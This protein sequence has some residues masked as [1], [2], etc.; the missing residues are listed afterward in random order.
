MK[1]IKRIVEEQI[2]SQTRDKLGNA[3]IKNVRS[4]L[5]K[6]EI[7]KDSLKP[8]VWT[9]RYYSFNRGDYFAIS[10]T[11]FKNYQ[12]IKRVFLPVS[13]SGVLIDGGYEEFY[14]VMYS[15]SVYSLNGISFS[16]PISV[17]NNTNIYFRTYYLDQVSDIEKTVVSTEIIP[18]SNMSFNSGEISIELPAGKWVTLELILYRKDSQGYIIGF[19]NLIEKIDDWRFSDSEPPE[20]PKWSDPPLETV[21]DPVSGITTNTLR[22]QMPDSLDW[23]GH[24]IYQ[25]TLL[26]KGNIGTQPIP[27]QLFKINSSGEIENSG[28]KGF[29][30]TEIDPSGLNTGSK[31]ELRGRKYTVAGYE[32]I[33]G[34]LINNGDFSQYT[35]KFKDWKMVSSPSLLN[36][37]S[38]S[39]SWDENNSGGVCI[40]CSAKA[41]G[42][43]KYVYLVHT[44]YTAIDRSKDYIL[45][46][47]TSYVSGSRT[48][49]YGIEYN[50]NNSGLL[51]ATVFFGKQFDTSDGWIKH[52]L[53]IK[54][55]TANVYNSI[56]NNCNYFRIRAYLTQGVTG[57]S[58]RIFDTIKLAEFN[59][60]EIYSTQTSNSTFIKT[61]E[62]LT[63]PYN[64]YFKV[65]AQLDKD[66]VFVGNISGLYQHLGQSRKR[67]HDVFNCFSAGRE[68][69]QPVLNYIKNGMFV[70]QTDWVGS[71]V[72]SFSIS[73]SN[74]Y[75]PPFG[76]S[77]GIITGKDSQKSVLK[78][79]RQTVSGAPTARGSYTLSVYAKGDTCTSLYLAGHVSSILKSTVIPITK[80]W[81]RYSLF[82]SSNSFNSTKYVYIGIPTEKSGTIRISGAQLEYRSTVT[83]FHPKP[84]NDIYTDGLTTRLSCKTRISQFSSDVF[85]DTNHGTLRLFYTPDYDSDKADTYKYLVSCYKNPGGNPLTD[86]IDCYYQPSSRQFIFS[87][88]KSSIGSS[89]KSTSQS[90]LRGD[91]LCL[92][93][94]WGATS[95]SIYVDGKSGYSAIKNF[96]NFVDYATIGTYYNTALSLNYGYPADGTIAE[97][98]TSMNQFNGKAIMIDAE[99]DGIFPPPDINDPTN[100]NIDGSQY[101]LIGERK[102][103]SEDVMKLVDGVF[104]ADPLTFTHSP[105]TPN[106]RY[107]YVISAYDFDRNP[108]IYSDEQW[109]VAGDKIPPFPITSTS[110]VSGY[111][112]VTYKWLNP[113]DDDFVQCKIYKTNVYSTPNVIDNVNGNPSEFNSWTTNTSAG[114]HDVYITTLDFN[115]NENKNGVKISCTSLGVDNVNTNIYVNWVSTAPA[116]LYFKSDASKL[117]AVTVT[118]ELLLA[119]PNSNYGIAMYGNDGSVLLS[120]TS[121]FSPPPALKGNVYQYI[122]SGIA[123]TFADGAE[124][125]GTIKFKGRIGNT[126]VNQSLAVTF[127]KTQPTAP[128]IALRNVSGGPTNYTGNKQVVTAQF[129]GLVSDVYQCQLSTTSG[130]SSN[131][132]VT[133]FNTCPLILPDIAKTYSIRGWVMDKAL[134]VSPVSNTLTYAYAGIGIKPG[135]T[136]RNAPTTSIIE[137]NIDGWYNQYLNIL[138]S[139]ETTSPNAIV[140][141]DYTVKRTNPVLSDLTGNVTGSGVTLTR[142][143]TLGGATADAVNEI[144]L[145]AT[146]RIGN[147]AATKLIVKQDDTKPSVMAS[148]WDNTVTGFNNNG[149]YLKWKTGSTDN[150]SGI[151]QYD[152]YRT[153]TGFP[154]TLKRIG[155]VSSTISYFTDNEDVL[156][157]YAS[158]DYQL[159]VRDIA[160]NTASGIIKSIN[161]VAPWDRTFRNW[162]DNGS[163][164]RDNNQS[165]SMVG[166][167][168]FSAS[169]KLSGSKSFYLPNSGSYLSQNLMLPEL[170]ST[171]IKSDDRYVLSFYI[172]N[173]APLPVLQMIYYD[174]TGASIVLASAANYEEWSTFTDGVSAYD[175]NNNEWKRKYRVFNPNDWISNPLYRGKAVYVRP[176]F[177]IPSGGANYIDNIQWEDRKSTDTT[178]TKFID[179]HTLTADRFH[180]GFIRANMIKV[181][182]LHAGLFHA[183]GV[184]IQNSQT[185]APYLQIGDYVTGES[186]VRFSQYGGYRHFPGD[187]LGKGYQFLDHVESG[188]SR[189]GTVNFRNTF[190]DWNGNQVIPKVLINLLTYMPFNSY[191][192]AD[193]QFIDIRMDVTPTGFTMTPYLAHI[194]PVSASESGLYEYAPSNATSPFVPSTNYDITFTAA[195]NVAPAEITSQVTFNYTVNWSANASPS[196]PEAVQV[197]F[198]TRD[199][200]GTYTLRGTRI[201]SS[202]QDET[203]NYE[204]TFGNQSCSRI[205]GTRLSYTVISGSGMQLTGGY[206]VG[207]TRAS[208][209]IGY[210]ALSILTGFPPYRWTA[211]HNLL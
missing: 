137:P 45:T 197:S 131:G 139:G 50:Q 52:S 64:P 143:I 75:R 172:R 184:E 21:S 168:A 157:G 98:I 177:N 150:L 56:P 23:A 133:D 178:P 147:T 2:K 47:Y 162:F 104:V 69:S 97:V 209:A 51:C 88:L 86:R 22:W 96:P 93:L 82:A 182:D 114:T 77:C 49:Q 123:V 210:G 18:A 146:D 68:F 192:G 165:W 207:V 134:N 35:T 28:N 149:A 170:T 208:R 80:N 13:P 55:A 140:R 160:D 102:K 181:G 41:T 200:V 203:V 101:E 120:T 7:D 193:D 53:F 106:Q 195:Y 107:T 175:A 1:E 158:Y 48:G 204:F 136:V 9:K 148:I 129:T 141:L 198:Y 130:Y 40:G 89:A 6:Q 60:S 4:F 206:W 42:S 8:M 63:V 24:L 188:E 83:Q 43:S 85:L 92:H 99:A 20:Q 74:A 126:D 124:G 100:N 135:I 108:S 211:F 31:L 103:T 191:W 34:N 122:K 95:K 26:S 116:G 155:S 159:Q 111:G 16:I 128:T 78:Y 144:T 166:G 167:A 65:Y 39:I 189:S 164:D 76:T 37:F 73:T 156:E 87:S 61:K 15:V 59:S 127:D 171:F 79:A 169:E 119:F 81:K 91:R 71:P 25:R 187:A 118:S 66:T 44:A 121:S 29:I 19:K 72:G 145:V 17:A 153:K 70:N 132:W 125:Y 10:D 11:L 180:A 110:K 54:H 3:D 36:A 190:V 38:S 57:A 142:T 94:N 202:M 199:S 30:L 5:F 109:I 138:L 14:N 186:F 32:E 201:V 174:Y 163:G 179:N 112:T 176:I 152:I 196:A 161:L 12:S 205:Y 113:S 185:G 151:K 115:G 27:D 46:L 105:L 90:F 33:K 84:F 154:T 183:N 62:N 67:T 194:A 173:A 58:S 117:F